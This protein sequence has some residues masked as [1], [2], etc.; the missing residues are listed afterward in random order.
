MTKYKHAVPKKHPP[1]R[2]ARP[3]I[4]FLVRDTTGSWGLSQWQGV[5]DKARERDINV[6]CF[7]GQ[8]LRE[9]NGFYAQGNVLYDL[10]SDTI[11][12][13]VFN[14]A[15][16]QFVNQEELEE[17][18]KR[19]H[20][21]PVVGFERAVRGIPTV[22][23][24]EYQSMREA[25]IH[26]IEAHGRRR[27]GFI[28]GSSGHLGQQERYRAYVDTL[29]EYGMSP[30]P[31]IVFHQTA[32]S[33]D[34]LAIIRWIAALR[35]DDL[36]ALVGV[37]DMQALL[38]LQTIQAQG[39]RI[40]ED[41]AVVGFDNFPEGR[42]AMLP[43]TTVQPP[44]YEMGQKA[45]EMVLALMA[46]EQVPDQVTLPGRVVR[47]ESCGCSLAPVLQAAVEE[48]TA[49]GGTLDAALAGR[50]EPTLSAMK[51]ELGTPIAGLKPQWAEQLLDAFAADVTHSSNGPSPAEPSP[52]APGAFVK[53]LDEPLRQ[54][55][56]ADAVEAWQG[57]LS[58]M[59]R[60]TLPCLV[61][62]APMLHRAEDL[63]G[64]ARVLIGERAQRAQAFQALQAEQR[65]NDLHGIG[66]DLLA[67]SDVEALMDVLTK[68]LPRLGIPSC[69][70]SVYEDPQPYLY[71]Q[72]APP[73]SRLLL[74]Y[75]ERKRVALEANGRRFPSRQL[76]PEDLWPQGRRYTYVIEPL[77]SREEQLGFVLFEEGP[78]DG[79]VFETLRGE[80]STALQGARLVQRVQ[81][82]SAELMRQ[83]YILDTFM[84]SI[85][86]F[87]YFK[88]TQSQLTR[89]NNAY[90]KR[91]G[92]QDPGE[93]IGK[94]DFDL[95][96][97]DQAE[98][99]YQQERE[100]IRTGQPI[101]GLEEP[102][103]VDRWAITTKMPLR[104]EKG[105]ILGTFGISTD[106]TELVKTKQAV[107]SRARELEQ[108]YETLQKQQ[109]V[110]LI[111]EK[112]ASLGRLTAGIA[113][114]M[115]TPLAAVRATLVN[116]D[117]LVKEYESSI[118]DAS[119]TDQDHL[120]IAQELHAK[121]RLA[122][123]AAERAAEFVRGIK[124]QTRGQA[125]REQQ[126]VNAVV[127]VEDALLLLSRALRQGKCT[128]KFEKSHNEIPLMG[129]PGH[130]EQVVTNLVNNA[131]GA[132]HPQGGPITV[133]L[134]KLSD[135]V[136]LRVGD[137]GCGIPP[138]NLSKIFDPMFSTKR[139]GSSTGLGLTIVHDIVVG[140]FGGSIDVASEPGQGATFTIRFP[141]KNEP[142]ASAINGDNRPGV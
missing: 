133:K 27:I 8:N 119:V 21:L 99:K 1:P 77:Y 29:A 124:S 101:L 117:E 39:I 64:Q 16:G 106:I 110:L 45:V 12:G 105:A 104:D 78:R 34:I 33:D 71:P 122:D 134:D 49:S 69:Y 20:P 28:C 15:L 10:F 83:Q 140:E 52:S 116:M 76:V 19:F 24:G 54:V 56:N 87:I 48:V 84:N 79:V 41:V 132:C 50:R 60:H 96:P 63:W 61:G 44:F 131:I 91:L 135:C 43:L 103:G 53:A 102:D 14:A 74:A 86:D 3:T 40:P 97:L 136:E 37:S 114:E 36:D 115:N 138:G 46:G 100:I 128:L 121:V 51:A 4:G 9:I 98:I 137:R 123:E 92:A 82:R 25:V 93:L 81:E 23:Q 26:L 141:L 94:S 7:S 113:H 11:D 38:A 88:N 112:M 31:K 90:A 80:I 85:P 47:R 22:F 108:A 5:V 68:G 109:Q 18:C 58:E 125:N 67:T 30:D 6:I 66:R 126:S 127:A 70:L 95:F 118:G 59:R 42:S 89:T 72:P 75:D 142:G 139:F 2:H 65:S 32:A 111:T 35:K 107:E 62:D 17:F 55:T 130:L 73:W 57:V 129:V 13:F 120:E